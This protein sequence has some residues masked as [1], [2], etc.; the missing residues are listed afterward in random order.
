MKK[1]LLLILM[2]LLPMLAW[3]DESGTCGGNLTWTYYESTHSLTISGIGNMNNYSGY[4][5]VYYDWVD[6]SPWF[7]LKEKIE[8][9]IMES[10]I[11]SIGNYSFYGCKNLTSVTIPN[12]VTSIG[13]YAFS[14]C[15]SLMSVTIPNSVTSIG[16]KAFLGCSG[17]NS[18]AVENGNLVF[19]SRNNCN[20][21][22]ESN[23]NTLLCGCKNTIIPNSVTSIGSGAFWGCSSLTSVTIPNSVTT[24]GNSAFRDC[25]GLTS[26]TIPNSVATI[27]DGVF[28]NCSGLT[29]VTI[30]NCVTSIGNWAFNKCSS[31]TSVSIPNSVTTIDG[32]FE[33]CSSLTTVTI[34][35]SVTSI[36]KSAFSGCSSLEAMEIPNSVTSIGIRAFYNCSSLMSMTIPNS[37]TDIG[38]YAFSGCTN[39]TDVYCYPTTVP[40]ITSDSFDA[41]VNLYV[42][43]VAYD[44][45]KSTSSWKS[46]QN[47]YTI[48]TYKLK[49]VVD[50]E[51]YYSTELHGGMPITGVERPTKEHYTFSGWSEQLSVMPAHD[52]TV[53]GSFTINHHRLVYILDNQQYKSYTLDYGTI[54]SPEANPEKEGYTFSGWSVI[55]ETMPDNDVYVYGSFAIN[56][57]KLTY[58]IDGEE[59]CS[60]DVEYDASIIAEPNPTKE[61]HTFSGWSWI[62]SKMPAENVTVTGSFT[63]NKYIITYIVDGELL[64]EEEVDYG[65]TI[66]P[67]TSQKE[68]Y[69]IVWGAHPTTMPAYNITIY[70]SYTTGVGAITLQE[71]AV[72]YLSVDGKRHTGLSKGLNIVRMS[73]GTTKKVVVK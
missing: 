54:I 43:G 17:L 32:A 33:N 68:G 27:A 49:Y 67:P 72:M 26:V 71:D 31:L 14:Y 51:D 60:Y 44:D 6:G 57:Y 9:I 15:S 18:I 29:S 64:T 21:I 41:G 73:N 46:Y 50:G 5:N 8:N 48:E 65:T 55:P 66:L 22:I 3:A 62:P 34:P 56:H 10:G 42:P 38:N 24:I 16:G 69:N 20:A 13:E 47:L 45:Y 40:T 70:G 12:S 63:V 28:E 2:T 37:V 58:L 53:A 19:D 52:V 35:N 7:S 30:P 23:S 59:Y 11:T 25:S 36:G 39:L 4:Y 61:G 1:Q